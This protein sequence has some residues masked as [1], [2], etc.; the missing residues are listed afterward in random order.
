[1]ASITI[2]S[3]PGMRRDIWRSIDLQTGDKIYTANDRPRGCSG[4]EGAATL[5]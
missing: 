1:M 5:K 4:W 2:G 3:H